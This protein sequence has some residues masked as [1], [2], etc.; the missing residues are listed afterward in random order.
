MNLSGPICKMGTTSEVRKELEF[1]IV[2][3]EQ[4]TEVKHFL[5]L[6]NGLDKH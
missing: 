1:R 4:Q 2:P 6:T 5:S 3:S